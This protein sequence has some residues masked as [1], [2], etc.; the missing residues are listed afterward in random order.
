MDEIAEVI[1]GWLA[2]QMQMPV[3]FVGNPANR[4]PLPY[5]TLKFPVDLH[6]V[7]RPNNRRQGTTFKQARLQQ[8]DAEIDA[9]GEVAETALKT[10]L[11]STEMPDVMALFQA[12]GL[13][14]VGKTPMKDLSFLETTAYRKRYQATVTFYFAEEVSVTY[15]T[16][17]EVVI[18]GPRGTTTIKGE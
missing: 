2:D 4:P 10:A 18:S 8:A 7:G 6:Q 1:R 17:D 16:I 15:S 12:N 13:S 3:V 9:F 14:E 11:D 5:A